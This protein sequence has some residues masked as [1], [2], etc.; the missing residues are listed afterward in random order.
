[1]ISKDRF[2][3]IMGTFCT[4][5]TIVTMKSGNECHGLTVS[6]FCSA[7]LEPPLILF[8]RKNNGM[9]KDELVEGDHVIINILSDSQTD[10]AFRFANSALNHQERF[11]EIAYGLSEND[12]PI[13][14]GCKS[15]LECEI[16]DQMEAGD[17]TVY[18]GRVNRGEVFDEKAPM[19][20]VAENFH[21]LSK[22]SQ[23]DFQKTHI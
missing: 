10:L 6:S 7:S 2:K 13:L 5:V 15:H 21:Q 20:Y 4:G 22:S 1:M 8:C 12:I 16:V 9:L 23:S 17:H 18:I 14:M 11:S 19:I 3:T